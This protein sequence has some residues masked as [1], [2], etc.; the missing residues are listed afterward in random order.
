MERERHIE[1]ETDCMYVVG[2]HA[3]RKIKKVGGKKV[4]LKTNCSVSHQDLCE[5]THNLPSAISC[6]RK[7]AST[8]MS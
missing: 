4:C 6:K 1:W 8:G 7:V 5:F 3:D 2:T